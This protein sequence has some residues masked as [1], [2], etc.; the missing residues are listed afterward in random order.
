MIKT[1]ISSLLNIKHPILQ[2]G[3]AWVATGELAAAVSNAGGL[4]IIGSGNAPPDI[5]KKEIIKVKERTDKP[6]GLNVMLLSPYAEEIIKL[7]YEEQI[8]IVTFGAGNPGKYIVK[9]K[10]KGT[11]VIPIV[12]SVALAKRME[13]A[14]A[15]AVIV[16]GTEAGGHIGETT[17]MALVPQV[18]DALNIPIIAAGGIADGRGFISALALGAEGVQMGTVFVCSQECTVHENYKKAIIKAS[19][20]NTSVSGRITGHPV[21]MIK[22]KL[23]RELIE[24]EKNNDINEFER[25]GTGSLRKACIEGDV[26]MGTV[27]A[28]QISGLIKDIKPVNVIIDGIMS[29]SEAIIE[30]LNNTM[31]GKNL[32]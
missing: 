8:P 7:I 26:V 19:D 5:I 12:P 16:E 28:G 14:G 4:G 24:T 20:R 1:R 22:N 9:L 2:G 18:A 3:M 11:V 23:H 30:K 13:S 10:D 31:K 21:R 32:C 25:L 15:D 27:M 29:E 17:T 6:F